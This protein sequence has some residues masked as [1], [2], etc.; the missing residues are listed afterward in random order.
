L[1]VVGDNHMSR[2]ARGGAILGAL[3]AALVA[4][5][6]FRG[7]VWALWLNLAMVLLGFVLAPNTLA[8]ASTGWWPATTFGLVTAAL[9]LGLVLLYAGSSVT[10][11]RSRGSRF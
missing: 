9:G 1:A 11:R 8:H 3:L 4:A 2:S 5:A 7:R 6:A 10:E